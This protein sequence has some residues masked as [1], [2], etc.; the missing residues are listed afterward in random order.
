VLRHDVGRRAYDHSR[1]MVWSA[2]GAEYLRLFGQVAA[3][4]RTVVQ[5]AP[6]AAVHV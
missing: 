4:S 1:K 2:V 6:E 3:D 5:A